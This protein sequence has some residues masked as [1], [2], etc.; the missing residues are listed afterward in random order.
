MQ[1]CIQTNQKFRCILMHIR[2]R[3]YLL[4]CLN[5]LNVFL[6]TYVMKHLFSL[7]LICTYQTTKACFHLL[8]KIFHVIF[9]MQWTEET[10]RKVNTQNVQWNKLKKWIHRCSL[11]KRFGLSR[12]IF[13]CKQLNCWDSFRYTEWHIGHIPNYFDTKNLFYLNMT[14]QF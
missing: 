9:K 4:E 11:P 6:S 10:H 12:S 8:S 14:R 5:C 13:E 1:H 2:M 7:W 3:K